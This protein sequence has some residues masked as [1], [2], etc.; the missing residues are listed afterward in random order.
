MTTI[1][2]HLLDFNNNTKW[3]QWTMNNEQWTMTMNN[4][5]NDNEQWTMTINNDS[6]ALQYVTIYTFW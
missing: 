2:M 6:N 3:L 1:A 4:N 5:N